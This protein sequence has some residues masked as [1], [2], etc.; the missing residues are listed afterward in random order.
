MEN[1]ILA[2]VGT[3]TVTEAEVT[4]FIAGLTTFMA[5]RRQNAPYLFAVS[6]RADSSR[7]KY[8]SIIRLSST[9]FSPYVLLFDC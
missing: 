6:V 2:K 7:R 9:V 5:M 8:N 3:L 1:K 4:E